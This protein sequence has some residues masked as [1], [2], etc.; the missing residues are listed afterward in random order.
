MNAAIR[1]TF[2][3]RPLSIKLYS[4]QA[5][6]LKPTLK[7][8]LPLKDSIKLFK[9]NVKL[10]LKPKLNKLPPSETSEALPAESTKRKKTLRDIITNE[11]LSASSASIS[12]PSPNQQRAV[13]YSTAEQYDTKKLRMLLKSH[14][15]LP[16]LTDDV[17]AIELPSGKVYIFHNGTVCFW[18]VS[19]EETQALLKELKACEINPYSFLESEYFDYFDD[20][21]QPGGLQQ[22]DIILGSDV[23]TLES[24]L[25]YS[26]GMTRSVKLASLEILLENHLARTKHV[27]GVLLDG[28]RVPLSS[29]EMLKTLGEL[30][31]LRGT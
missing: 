3:F 10:T 28:G 8:A 12:A 7:Q 15:Q 2:S 17:S 4:T 19:R 29:N 24:Q 9:K 11:N 13:A 31:S 23:S 16:K 18:G 26:F 25:V 6:L 20:P 22:D 5:K 1:A 27:P 21:S 14:T 30:F